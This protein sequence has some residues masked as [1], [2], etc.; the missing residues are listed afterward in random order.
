MES[1]RDA[2]SPYE[3]FNRK[4]EDFVDDLRP[5]IGHLPEYMLVSSGIKWLSQ[6]DAHKNQQLF[7]MYVLSQYED[8]IVK[9]DE[10]F[11]LT[12]DNYGY[13]DMNVV[14]LLKSVWSSSLTTNDKNAVWDHMQVLTLLSRRCRESAAAAGSG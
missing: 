4:L 14:Q 8:H 12:S 13:T 10:Q 5:V 1:L 11:F 6:Y 2:V 9:R 3:L 7:D